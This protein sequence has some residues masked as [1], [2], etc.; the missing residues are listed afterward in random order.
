[1]KLD[2]Y[3]LPQID[4]LLS[5]LTHA[6]YLSRIDLISGYH[7]VQIA[8]GNELKIAFVL[9]FGLCEFTVLLFGLCNA[10]STFICLINNV[11]SDIIDQNVLF[12][13]DDI[14]VYS[15]AAKNHE[16]HLYEVFSQLCAYKIQEK[17]AK[18]EFGCAYIHYL[19]YIVGPGKLKVDIEKVFAVKNWPMP[20]C[21]RSTQQ[22]LG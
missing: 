15:K 11:F 8:P 19:S 21:I 16:K 7:Q 9:R 1:M 13:L 5:I 14:L 6:Y 22:F 3:P 17:Y 18:C 20:S 12:Y 4:Y 2:H 10:P